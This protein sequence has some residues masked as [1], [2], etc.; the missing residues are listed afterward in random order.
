MAAACIYMVCTLIK[1]HSDRT[2]AK[3]A[4]KSVLPNLMARELCK[5]AL[6]LEL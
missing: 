2:G 1:T 6:Q 3:L 5:C 4:H